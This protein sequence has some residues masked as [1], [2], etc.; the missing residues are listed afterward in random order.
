MIGSPREGLETS[1]ISIRRSVRVSSRRSFRGGGEAEDLIARRPKKL[2]VADASS[3]IGFI[4]RLAS[5]IGDRGFSPIIAAGAHLHA[6]VP[7]P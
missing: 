4:S 6:A 2:H 7:Q 3:A 5:L 1:Q